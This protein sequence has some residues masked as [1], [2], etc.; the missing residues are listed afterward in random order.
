M[1]HLPPQHFHPNGYGAAYPDDAGRA[2]RRRWAEALAAAHGLQLVDHWPMPVIG[3]DCYLMETATDGKLDDALAAL[4]HDRRVL[5]AQPLQAYHGLDGGDPLYPLQPSA[6]YWELAALHRHSTGRGVRIALIDSAVDAGHPDLDGQLVVREDFVGSPAP[7]A[8][9]ELHGTAV[10]GIIGARAGNGIGIAGVAPGARLLALRACWNAGRGATLCN[11]F[12]LSKALNFAI[13]N[14]ARII[15]MSLG[16]PP[17]P[18]LRLLLDAAA[19]RGMAVVAAADPQAA[20]GAFPASHAGVIAVG[21]QRPASARAGLLLAP[22]SD[23][24]TTLPDQR[25][26]F[27][28]GSSYAAAQVSGLFALLA[29]L[30]P[31]ASA[32]Q[33][34]ARVVEYPVHTHDGPGDTAALEAGSIDACATIGRISQSCA[35]LCPALATTVKRALP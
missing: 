15:N 1:T 30:L 21:I 22:G 10:A 16:G 17:D 33:L 3:V 19:R 13:M 29:Q 12:T 7:A 27:V 11:S 14:D 9:G 4:A 35:C 31:E 6:R 18:L 32:A 2:A 5:W 24:P 26:G 8:G 20:D 28:S 34:R 23:I 25:W